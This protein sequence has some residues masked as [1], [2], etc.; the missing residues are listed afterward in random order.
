MQ[1]M[2]CLSIVFVVDLVHWRELSTVHN[3]KIKYKKE[4]MGV[5]FIWLGLI[6]ERS[7]ITLIIL[8]D[9]VQYHNWEGVY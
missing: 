3:W 2:L 4:N 6:E 8:G 9:D 5:L 1:T 7:F